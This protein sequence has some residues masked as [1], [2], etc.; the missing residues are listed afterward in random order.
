ME[1]TSVF[2][3]EQNLLPFDFKIHE[4]KT[5]LETCEAIETMITR[6]A[7]AIGA[8]AGFAMAQAF[9][10]ATGQ[11][12]TQKARESIE[13]TRPTAQNL[14]YATERV[15]NAGKTSVEKALEEANNIA[16]EDAAAC[17]KIGE[18]GNELIKDSW[19]SVV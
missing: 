7:G 8:T 5:H 1:K 10:E 12:Y 4:A 13:A 15:Y 3:I 16:N 19:K 2:L 9:M 6:G 11:D 18:Y 17:K 14:F